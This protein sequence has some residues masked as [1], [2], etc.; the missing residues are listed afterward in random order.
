MSLPLFLPQVSTGEVQVFRATGAW[1]KPPNISFVWFFVCGGGAGGGAGGGSN[2]QGG[3]GGGGSS[4]AYCSAL[5]AANNVPDTLLFQIGAGGA[6]SSDGGATIITGL[7]LNQT[8]A[9]CDGG[10][11]GGSGSGALPG[12][13][14]LG[15]FATLS[16]WL[17]AAICFFS[18]V[19]YG[20]GDGGDVGTPGLDGVNNIV[21]SGAGGGFGDD[22]GATSGGSTGGVIGYWTIPGGA[23]NTSAGGSGYG[24]LRQTFINCGG[25]GG[26]GGTNA[27]GRN[28][29]NAGGFGSGGGGGGGGSSGTTSG[30]PGGAGSPGV[31]LLLSW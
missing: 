10:T 13:G 19:G 17:N 6:P 25:S 11:Q 5:F 20:G 16:V 7:G 30:A 1:T 23:A 2:T 29:G 21:G 26:G 22:A 28:G 14:G 8:L 3:G 15:G 18:N 12:G 31:A 4:G 27:A 24:T 9:T